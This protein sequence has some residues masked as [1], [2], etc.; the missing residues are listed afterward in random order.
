MGMKLVPVKLTGTE[1]QAIEQLILYGK[2]R[3]VSGALREGL[4]LLLDFHKVKF[5]TKLKIRQERIAH[6]M[7]KGRESDQFKGV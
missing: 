7:R 4:M 2:A 3:T 5:E 6:P 1:I